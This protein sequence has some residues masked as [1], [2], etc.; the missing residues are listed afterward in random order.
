M[1]LTTE[2]RDQRSLITGAGSDCHAEPEKSV[3]RISS[4]VTHGD[5]IA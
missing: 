3:R 2:G 4:V 1:R 5:V